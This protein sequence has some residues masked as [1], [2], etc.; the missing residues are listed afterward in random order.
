MITHTFFEASCKDFSD[1]GCSLFTMWQKSSKSTNRARER[2]TV[3]TETGLTA[4]NHEFVSIH[5]N[6]QRVTLLKRIVLT[7]S[8]GID[9]RCSSNRLGVHG[10]YRIRTL[11]SFCQATPW[12]SEPSQ[13]SVIWPKQKWLYCKV[14]KI[15]WNWIVRRRKVGFMKHNQ[16]HS[17]QMQKQT[18]LVPD[19]CRF[20][21]RR[22]QSSNSRDFLH[23][24]QRWHC[25]I[26]PSNLSLQI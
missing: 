2:H 7:M 1:C 5:K 9:D 24:H 19:P 22:F 6:L 8:A 3:W 13:T 18:H 14:T 21:P 16:S 25:Q 15:D 17:Y 12:L 23:V 26:Y 11:T 20:P 4:A 10:F